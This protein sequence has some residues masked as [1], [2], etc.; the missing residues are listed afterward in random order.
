M[1]K[2]VVA[3]LPL[4]LLSRLS[5]WLPIVALIAFAFGTLPTE[6]GMASYLAGL[7]CVVALRFTAW[8]EGHHR[9]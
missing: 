2:Q 1:V 9:Q 7:L 6:R 5:F 4:W 8:G 3:R